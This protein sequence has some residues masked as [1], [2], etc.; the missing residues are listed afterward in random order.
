[1]TFDF[2][3]LAQNIGTVSSDGVKLTP[4]QLKDFVEKLIPEFISCA[5]W[6]SPKTMER[7]MRKHFGFPEKLY[8]EPVLNY[9]TVMSVIEWEGAVT[10]REL[11]EDDGDGYW[12]KDG[13]MS[14]LSVW[15]EEKPSWATHVAWFNK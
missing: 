14:E 10:L 13:L 12:V 3:S 4:E 7:Q 1:M 6:V 5:G 8:W 9:A 11:I 2:Q 15:A